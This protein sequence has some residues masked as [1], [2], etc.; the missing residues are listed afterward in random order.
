[1]SRPQELIKSAKSMDDSLR[2]TFPI[3]SLTLCF[4]CSSNNCRGLSLGK[5]FCRQEPLYL[6]LPEGILITHVKLLTQ[7]RSQSCFILCETL[8]FLLISSCFYLTTNRNNIATVEF[9]K[10]HLVL[11]GNQLINSDCAICVIPT[12]PSLLVGSG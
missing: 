3:H 2:L 10:T 1:M 9:H 8:V 12:L 11:F 7:S 5:E 4:K 6:R